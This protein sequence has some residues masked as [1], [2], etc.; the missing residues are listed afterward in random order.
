VLQ[1]KIEKLWLVGDN[2]LLRDFGL[3]WIIFMNVCV[4][5]TVAM[6]KILR[7]FWP[8]GIIIMTVRV[9]C[10]RDP[11]LLKGNLLLSEQIIK[12]RYC[13]RM[14]KLFTTNSMTQ[15]LFRL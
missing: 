8:Y 1:L 11:V 7:Y 9:C 3:Y 13:K 5:I 10:F 6:V 15:F 12:Y 2:L 4:I 14:I